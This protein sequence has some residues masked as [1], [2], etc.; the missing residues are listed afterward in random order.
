VAGLVGP[1]GAGRDCRGSQTAAVFAVFAF[2]WLILPLLSFG[3]DGTLDPATLALYP[4]RAR[5][6]ATGLLGASASGA[7]PLAN[8]LG[9]LGVLS[10]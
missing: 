4:L 8:V 9:L 3:L 1:N 7:W 6:L 2:G 10:R 5:S